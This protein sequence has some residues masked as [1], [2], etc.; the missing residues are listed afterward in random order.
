MY[1]DD[2]KERRKEIKERKKKKK[3]VG[4]TLH[5]EKCYRKA[6]YRRVVNEDNGA[7]T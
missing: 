6:H 4:G 3:K 1:Y 2:E 5:G 7:I